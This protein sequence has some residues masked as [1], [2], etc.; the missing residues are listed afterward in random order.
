MTMTSPLA[1]NP[2]AQAFCPKDRAEWLALRTNDVT[3]SD[4][5][6]LFGIGRASKYQLWIE[7]AKKE[8]MVL[9]D[10]KRMFWG[11][12]LE[13]AIA[14]GICEE[15]GW[16]LIDQ[17][18]T[19]YRDASVGMGAT[20]D[21]FVRCPKRGFGLLQIK[22]VDYIVFKQQWTPAKDSGEAPDYIEAQLQCELGVTGLGWGAIGALVAGND[23][24]I[25]IREAYPDVI[26]AMQ[27]ECQRFWKSVTDGIE[28]PMDYTSDS[29]FIIKLNSKS[30]E[31]KVLDMSADLTLAELLTRYQDASAREKNAGEEKDAIKAQIFVMVGDA[32][33]VIAGDTKL[34]VGTT[35]DTEGT[36]ITQE[37]VGTRTGARKGYRKL[38]ISQ[39]KQ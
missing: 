14:Q 18:V 1:T 12:K 21:F 35:K 38:L 31:G 9:A 39:N 25:Y 22:N 13:L 8:V 33:K 3:A 24:H 16:E 5:G 4:I 10:N 28:P 29:E 20:P 30:S 27:T 6:C 32:E 23:H 36:L 17:P 2:N 19:Y 7:K 15:M 37:M 34:N 26:K 11:R